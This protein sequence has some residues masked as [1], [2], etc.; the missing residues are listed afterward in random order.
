MAGPFWR[1]LLPATLVLAA[2][3]GYSPA[4]A[5]TSVREKTPQAS[6][7]PAGSAPGTSAPA[8]SFPE[9]PALPAPPTVPTA[10]PTAEPVVEPAAPDLSS[11]QKTGKVTALGKTADDTH[12]F[13]ERGIL[14]QV[15]R[16]DDFF[17]KT[18]GQKPLHAAYLLRWR[19]SLRVQQG[20]GLTFGSALRANLDLSK[21][22]DRLQLSIS[23][24]DKPDP[25]APSLPEDPGTPGF[26]R[27]FTTARI[28]NTELRY[29][30]IRSSFTDLFLGAG[31]E[32][33]LPTRVFGRV[34]FQRSQKIGESYLARFAETL[35]VKSPF[36]VGE[37][38][39]LDFE[40][41]LDPGTVLRWASSGTV[42]QEIQGLEWGSE[43]SL[44]HELSPRS[45]V[46]LIGGFYGNTSFPDWINNYRM[47]VRY[48]RNFLR[49]WLFYELEP[50]VAWPRSA[51]GSFPINYAFTARIEVVFRG[52]ETDALDKP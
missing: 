27:T 35:F 49:S 13:L 31:V 46:T 51:G 11:K 1:G 45:A 29:Q 43:L 10:T 15:I 2:C 36:G 38:T 18:N 3:L 6:S 25:F 39:E 50:Q 26:D 14:H 42:S 33:A 12:D 32:L 41:L 23:G 20:D 24:E 9:E 37:T 40:R 17:G 19:N 44:L 28:V 7:A 48:R 8:L 22:N 21:I 30:L 5:E 16:L 52:V 47:L 4:R 34:R